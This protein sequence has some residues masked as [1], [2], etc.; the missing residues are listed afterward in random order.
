[1]SRNLNDK[2][3]GEDHEFIMDK[4]SASRDPVGDVFV[5]DNRIFRG[6]REEFK[7]YYTGV[8]NSVVSQR[9][10]GSKIVPTRLS[11]EELPGYALSL[12]H[13][14]ILP[15][16]YAFEWTV[17]MLRDAAV[18]TLDICIDLADEGWVLKDATPFNI[19]F[20]GCSPIWV[21]FTSI[22][23]QE[24][25]LYWVAYDQFSRTFL[26]PLLLGTYLNGRAVRSMFL[27]N[28][29]GIS[30]EETKKYLPSLAWLRYGWLLGRLYIP[31]ALMSM[32]RQSGTEDDLSKLKTS[33]SEDTKVRRAFFE[34]VKGNLLSIKLPDVSS[35]WSNY[36][37]DIRT[38]FT[39]SLYDI[40]QKA[41]ADYIEKCKPASVVDIGCNQG[42][43][44][45]I[46]SRSG[47]KVIAF[48]SDEDSISL[49]YRLV[50]EKNLNILP[51]VGDVVYP[52]PAS[53]WL[54]REFKPA[55][56]RFRSEMALA[57]A[58][59]HHLAITQHQTFDRIT[60]MLA[61]YTSRW[62]VTEFV[63]IT[64][65]RS[66]EISRTARRDLSWY[67]LEN[68]VDALK[69]VF[70]TVDLVP[71]HPEGRVLCFCER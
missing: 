32:A 68:F 31:L 26:F 63:P 36:Y 50:T 29:N 44:S 41:V 35:M 7:P 37:T 1:M 15:A 21:D 8:L 45:V 4:L 48:D 59:V 60:Y 46:A 43:Y 54:G 13:K 39:P 17:S 5:K 49:L 2:K 27:G 34:G 10:L 69:K 12:E 19:I 47:A 14:Y 55:Q 66:R 28:Q 22:M 65:P 30:P 52:S 70:R 56:E 24:K 42:G 38:F 71:S 53:G 20:D 11:E 64:D 18:T 9:L 61:E 40:K 23:P 25:D 16:N 67:T 3:K 33:I 51:L 57:L 62:L 58:L 6:I